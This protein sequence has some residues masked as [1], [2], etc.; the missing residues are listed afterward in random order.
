[1][2]L[3]IVPGTAREG[4]TMASEESLFLSPLVGVGVVGRSALSL[5]LVRDFQREE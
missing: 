1:V 5:P 3:S 2:T 4:G